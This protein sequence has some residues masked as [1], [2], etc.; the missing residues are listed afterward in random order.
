[1]ART[2]WLLNELGAEVLHPGE[3]LWRVYMAPFGL[4]QN[5]LARR[6]GVPPR[7]VNQIVHGKRAITARTALR[8]GRLFGGDGMDWLERQALWDLHQARRSLGRGRPRRK[9]HAEEL[10]RIGRHD[11]QRAG[12]AAAREFDEKLQEHLKARQIGVYRPGFGL[13]LAPAESEV[14]SEGGPSGPDED[15][16]SSPP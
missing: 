11:R 12:A 15:L 7:C 16:S 9:R 6:L 8:L 14:P 2:R 10:A 1:M 3:V 4:S 13:A 5:E